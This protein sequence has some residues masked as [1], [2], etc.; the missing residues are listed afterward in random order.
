MYAKG[1]FCCVSRGS[2]VCHS[3]YIQLMVQEWTFTFLGFWVCKGKACMMPSE[4]EMGCPPLSISILLL[5]YKFCDRTCSL[6]GPWEF[7]FVLHGTFDWLQGEHFGAFKVNAPST[8]MGFTHLNYCC[9]CLFIY[10]YL[11]LFCQDGSQEA[12][13]TPSYLWHTSPLSSGP[14]RHAWL[15]T[16]FSVGAIDMN[17]GSCVCTSNT[18]PLSHL[19][20][21]TFL[22]I[23]HEWG[24]KKERKIR[25]KDITWPV[26][27]LFL[28]Q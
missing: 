25:K 8:F 6:L 16:A 2:A 26:D 9:I 12:H 17:S 4:I 21:L 22:N 18:L 3:A 10:L 15:H 7:H 28:R 14:K 23:F 27:L 11:S 5:S 19:S 13:A 1:H 20:S 24:K